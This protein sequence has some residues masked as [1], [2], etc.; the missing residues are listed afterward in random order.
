MNEDR[1]NATNPSPKPDPQ[2][3]GGGLRG[4]P[5]RWTG[6]GPRPARHV[7]WPE[8]F[9]HHESN[10]TGHLKMMDMVRKHCAEGTGN[11][12][13]AQ[14]CVD[15]TRKMM[16]DFREVKRNFVPPRDEIHRVPLG[17]SSASVYPGYSPADHIYGEAAQEYGKQI[18]DAK[19]KGV[20]F[21]LDSNGPEYVVGQSA[22]AKRD[23][24]ATVDERVRQG[25][26]DNSS[27]TDDGKEETMEGENVMETDPEPMDGVEQ[28][29][30]MFFF[31]SNPTPVGPNG[32]AKG[33]KNDGSEQLSKKSKKRKDDDA[34]DVKKKAAD[35]VDDHKSKRSKISL[36]AEPVST[37][38]TE[39][40]P[41]KDKKDK[42]KKHADDNGDKQSEQSTEPQAKKLKTFHEPVI[43]EDDIE[44]EVES[45]LR[46]KEEKRKRRKEKKRKRE[47]EASAILAA[48]ESE[49]QAVAE[50]PKK[51]KVKN[52]ET[53]RSDM[54]KPDS[55]GQSNSKTKKGKKRASEEKM[56]EDVA[57]ADERSKKK[58]KTKRSTD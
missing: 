33:H 5:R 15:R 36:T 47:S 56:A 57:E 16:S 10:L 29:P 58:K 19:K 49:E 42:K 45:R 3:K 25:L 38:A 35:A 54:Q 23:Q 52:R 27:N 55:D 46:E 11:W 39:D 40:P 7:P 22:K 21:K 32:D 41:K 8:L 34:A 50:E 13:T 44:A 31:D 14:A 18:S 51:K 9:K 37:L 6:S 2:F 43:E 24:L 1:L 53:D 48:A 12:Q 26:K 30:P 28:P 17:A 4:G 20:D